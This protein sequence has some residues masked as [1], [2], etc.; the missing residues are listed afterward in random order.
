MKTKSDTRINGFFI[1]LLSMIVLLN[2]GCQSP[3]QQK[4]TYREIDWKQA[5][6]H[7]IDTGSSD[8]ILIKQG[9]QAA[10]IDGG[11]NDDEVLLPAYIKKQGIEELQYL[12]ATHPDADHIGGLDGVVKAMKVHSVY[13]GNGQA[14]T[15]TYRDLI[16]ALM[17][18]GL[19]PSV[20]LL[21][22]EFIMG[23]SSFKVLSV[24][25]DKDV[26]NT[27][28][29]LLYTNGE[30]KILLMGDA[31]Q[32][33]EKTIQT[34]KINLIKVGHHGSSTS[35]GKAFLEQV[36]PDYAVI[37]VGA[38]N[39]YGHPHKE[40]MENLK[41][42]NIPVYRTDEG[43]NLLFI[44]TGR[45]ITT[46]HQL[47]SYTPGSERLLDKEKIAVG[48]PSQK[49]VLAVQNEKVYFTLQGKK[50][51]KDPNCSGMKSPQQGS[52]EDAGNRA[53]CSKCY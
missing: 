12:F 19:T 31:D 44:S 11:D 53:S 22:S 6:I 40:T 17:D 36:K 4:E 34:E 46:P 43:G 13:V 1:V 37:T 30:D 25:H 52:V 48:S 21:G 27:S 14:E 41:A 45:G 47:G 18:N 2:T 39:Q 35:S 42:L 38:D 5:E 16:Q 49:S 28:L 23:E 15:K 26:N 50:Y 9:D 33:I 3:G 29:V 20:P 7:F 8:A 10:L 24:A 51:H 32:S